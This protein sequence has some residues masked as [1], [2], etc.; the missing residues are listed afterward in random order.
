M[1]RSTRFACE[2]RGRC[3]YGR[4]HRNRAAN[5]MAWKKQDLGLL[6]CRA[7]DCAIG[8]DAMAKWTCALPRR[9]SKSQSLF[10]NTPYQLGHLVGQCCSLCCG[11]LLRLLRAISILLIRRVLKTSLDISI[12]AIR[13]R[14]N[15]HLKIAYGRTLSQGPFY[16]P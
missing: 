12:G 11:R 14:L 3:R 15:K 16:P 1:L 10:P 9:P 5:Y 2:Y 4:H 6:I 8:F 13:S 7:Y